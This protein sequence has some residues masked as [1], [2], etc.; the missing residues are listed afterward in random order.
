M[1]HIKNICGGKGDHIVRL[2]GTKSLIIAQPVNI[3]DKWG[4]VKSLWHEQL[5][6]S[7]D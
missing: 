5:N 4:G 1:F 6:S 3:N 7:W 2:L